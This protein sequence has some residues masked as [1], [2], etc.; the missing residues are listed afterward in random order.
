[1]SK[2]S[3][4]KHKASHKTNLI[5]QVVPRQPWCPF[6]YSL[7]E[8]TCYKIPDKELKWKDA[9]AFC[10]IETSH[11]VTINNKR[12]DVLLSSMRKSLDVQE[13]W[14]GLNDVEY[15][16]LFQWSDGSKVRSDRL[17]VLVVDVMHIHKTP[18]TCVGSQFYRLFNN[19]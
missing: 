16:E 18:Q 1:M 3:F 13:V 15:E 14:I 17:M 10:E 9:K 2:F 5:Y 19:L 12:E 8:S 6:G 7:F 4:L 11:L